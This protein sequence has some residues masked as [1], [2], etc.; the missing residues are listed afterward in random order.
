MRLTKTS[1]LLIA[2]FLTGFSFGGTIVHG[3]FAEDYRKLL[4]EHR[5][6][7][8]DRDYLY[9]MIEQICEDSGDHA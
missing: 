7:V 6:V 4:Q 9:E 3:W 2:G 5:Q 8:R 1:A